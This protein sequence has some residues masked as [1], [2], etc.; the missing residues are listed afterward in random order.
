MRVFVFGIRGFPFIGGGAERHS[1]ELYPR[2]VKRGYDVTVLAR[3]V[4]LEGWKGIKFKKIRYHKNPRLETMT[5]SILCSLY[6]IKKKPDV[7]HIHNMGACLLVPLLVLMNLRVVLTLHSFNYLHKKW[8]FF[9]RFILNT[10]ENLGINFSHRIITVSKDMVEFLRN[11]YQR[12]LPLNYIPNAIDKAEHIPAGFTL[13]K[14]KLRE[15][16]YALAVGRLT[17]EKGFDCLV[18]AYNLAKPDFKLVIIGD[19]DSEYAKELRRNKSEDIIFTGYL[20]GKDLAELYSNAGLMV[21]SSF[22][23]GS[24]LVFLE[25]LNYGIPIIASNIR[26]YKYIPL[27]SYRYYIVD[28]IDELALKMKELFNED[29]TPEEKHYHKNLL[30]NEY[31]WDKVTKQTQNIYDSV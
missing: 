29:F 4:H 12:T 2:L 27:P 16:K 3:T 10:C 22:N 6:C 19:G 20:N 23:E 28:D 24:P 11:K 5:H 18:K 25:A 15:K 13:K 14:Y 26:A 1:E 9:A 31:N 17:P 21:L 8:N 7:V 30:E